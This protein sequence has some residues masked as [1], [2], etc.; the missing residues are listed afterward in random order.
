M[1]IMTLQVCSREI[2][3]IVLL[4]Q[5]RHTKYYARRSFY[6]IGNVSCRLQIYVLLIVQCPLCKAV[7][8]HDAAV[9]VPHSL[10]PCLCLLVTEE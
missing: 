10:S 8:I 9:R 6:D 3:S 4:W 1:H 2:I 5:F 7:I